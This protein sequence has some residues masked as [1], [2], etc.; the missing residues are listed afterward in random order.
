ML[1]KVMPLS[2]AQNSHFN[3][4]GRNSLYFTCF[5]REISSSLALKY[6]DVLA[7]HQLRWSSLIIKLRREFPFTLCD[8]L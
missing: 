7:I 8:T 2:S 6:T 3:Q 1:E 5:H 4:M